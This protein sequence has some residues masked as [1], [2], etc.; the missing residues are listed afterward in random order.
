M[1]RDSVF[2]DVDDVRIERP[3]HIYTLNELPGNNLVINI[4]LG[5]LKCCFNYDTSSLTEI[6]IRDFVA[7]LIDNTKYSLHFEPGSNQGA[8][9]STKDGMTRFNS[10]GAGGNNP[11]EITVTVPNHYCISAFE[12]L[13]PN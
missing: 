2:Y 3:D 10:Y 8:S 9:I 4:Q 13:L 11:V 6:Q 12:K 5:E 1:Q 7:A